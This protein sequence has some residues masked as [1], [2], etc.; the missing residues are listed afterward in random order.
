MANLFDKNGKKNELHHG[1][2]VYRWRGLPKSPDHFTKSMWEQFG[3]KPIDEKECTCFV[4]SED[5]REY[6]KIFTPDQVKPIQGK[7]AA[8]RREIFQRFENMPAREVY[9]R[10]L[11]VL[12]KRQHKD[13]DRALILLCEMRRKDILTKAKHTNFIRGR[14]GHR[15]TGWA[16]ITR[17]SQWMT[18]MAAY[19]IRK[20]EAV[21]NSRYF[22]SFN[23]GHQFR[24]QVREQWQ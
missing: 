1:K 14:D 23:K 3:Y 11:S 22:E 10:L 16:S 24:N 12:R 18:K 19:I 21:P 7:D 2:P 15:F 6:W 9:T 13:A 8:V 17:C 20:A 5:N 4:Q